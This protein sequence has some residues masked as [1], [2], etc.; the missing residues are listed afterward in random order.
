[1]RE[2]RALDLLRRGAVPARQ[3]V[4]SE[5]RREVAR[6]GEARPDGRGRERMDPAPLLPQVERRCGQPRP[7]LA[8]AGHEVGTCSHELAVERAYELD[9]PIAVVVLPERPDRQAGLVLL[10]G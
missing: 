1:M 8:I 3:I 7:R 4:L 10:N 6:R 9:V 2:R 5:R